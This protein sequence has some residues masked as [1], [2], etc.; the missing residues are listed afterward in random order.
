MDGDVLDPAKAVS[1]SVGQCHSEE[2]GIG[3]DGEG[4]TV[5]EEGGGIRGC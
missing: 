3:V 1:S 4:N 5:I 2:A